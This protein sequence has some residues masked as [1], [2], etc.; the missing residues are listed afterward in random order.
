MSLTAEDREERRFDRRERIRRR[1]ANPPPKRL[2]KTQRQPVQRTETPQRPKRRLGRPPSP[3]RSEKRC[4]K[5]RAVKPIAEYGVNKTRHDGRQ[6]YCQKC[7]RIAMREYREKRPQH[8]AATEGKKQ[9][10]KC[11]EVK[12][13]SAFSAS[14]D[15]LGGRRHTCRACVNAAW[16]LQHHR[17]MEAKYG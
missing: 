11:S 5:C 4:P 8:E 1:I 6:A 13:V 16:R 3:P 17:R 9:C 2:V 7:Y 10:N 14:P 12:D 15:Y